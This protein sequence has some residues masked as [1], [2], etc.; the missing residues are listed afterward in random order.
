MAA[1]EAA[2]E[3]PGHLP[4]EVF[5]LVRISVPIAAVDVL[6]WRRLA[7]GGVEVLLVRRHDRGGRVCWCWVGGRVRIDEPLAAALARHVEETLGADAE[8]TEI[9]TAHPDAVI[10]YPR[11]PRGGPHDEAQHSIA[12]TYL[13]EFRGGALRA[14]GEALDLRWFDAAEL[15][16]D[17]EFSF[18]LGPTIRRMATAA[19]S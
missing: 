4:D 12:M 14:G 8:L 2:G 11:T 13:S 15:P 16:S 7:E 6:P 3:G 17:E 19:G 10:E 9:D 18:G 1:T 5:A